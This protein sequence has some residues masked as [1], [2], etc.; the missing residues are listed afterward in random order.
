[1][2]FLIG[3]ALLF[4]LT[5]CGC[6]SSGK[7]DLSVD[8]SYLEKSAHS[9][10]G[11]YLRLP[12]DRLIRQNFLLDVRARIDRLYYEISPTHAIIFEKAFTDSDHGKA[13]I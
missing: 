12:D 10:A 1:M 8:F 11:R 7:K 5:S 4:S 9:Y 3:I 6:G 2:K 13:K